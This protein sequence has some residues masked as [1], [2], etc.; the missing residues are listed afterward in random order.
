VQ[1]LV[2]G[3]ALACAAQGPEVHR[4]LDE[5]RSWLNPLQEPEPEPA[6]QKGRAPAKTARPVCF[7]MDAKASTSDT[8]PS[9]LQ[10]TGIETH[11]FS[12]SGS[13]IDGLR[14]AIPNFV[15]LEVAGEGD[16]AIDALF[17]L[18][19]RTYRGPV[20]LMAADGVRALDSVRRIGERHSLKLPLALKTPLT[21]PAIRHVLQAH[22]LEQ[23]SQTLP[24]FRLSDVLKNRWIEFWY[25]PKIDLRR[26]TIAG[27]ET[28]ARLRHP[29]LGMLPPGCFM[30]GADARSLVAL[31]EH[32]LVS[33]LTAA[34]SFEQIG[35]KLRLAVNVSL[36]ALA[37]LK[38]AGII[39][40]YGPKAENW[41]GLIL[42]ITEEQIVS[43]MELTQNVALQL[44]GCNVKL[45]I[46]DFG[47]GHLSVAD[48]SRLPFAELKLDRTFVD[49]CATIESRAAQCATEIDLAHAFGAVAVAIG[50]EKTADAKKLGELDCDIGQGFLFGQPIPE[51]RFVA[52]LRERRVAASQVPSMQAS[53]PGASRPATGRERVYLS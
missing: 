13:F 17:A 1:T 37:E 20:Q 10:A 40:Q 46:D 42:D 44:S 38:V 16:E 52:L 51:D 33:A 2:K 12:K 35:I 4:V 43:D 9:V 25:Q 39:G 6:K 22:G 53:K 32:A 47:R 11:L 27:V 29:E 24:Q 21:A 19:E 30:P 34:R 18:G 28:F 3:Y 36:T 5:I 7:V 45:A 48:L 23:S 49:E 14:T 8:L 26:R 50:V 15:F 31:T 41:P